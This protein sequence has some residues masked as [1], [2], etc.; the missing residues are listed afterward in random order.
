DKEEQLTYSEL[1]RCSNQ[2]AA[3]LIQEGVEKGDAVAV[4][5]S[6]DIATIINVVG[7]VKAGGIYIAI[8]KEYPKTRKEYILKNSN[9]KKVLSTQ[10]Y[11]EEIKDRY[12]SDEIDVEVS[13]EDIAYIIYTSGSTGEPKGVVISQKAVTNTIQD[14]NERFHVDSKD[15]IIGVSSMCFDLSVYDVFGALSTG[16]TLILVKDQRDPEELTRTVLESGV[17]IWNTVP[18]IMN[19]MIEHIAENQEE[20]KKYDFKKLRTI[21]LSGDWIPLKLPENIKNYFEKS[22]VISLGGATEASIWSIYYPINQMDETWKSIPYGMPLANQTI[23]ILSEEQKQ[24]PIGTKGEI[25]IGGKGVASGYKKDKEK[26]QKAF[27]DHDEL[28]RIYRT[29]DYG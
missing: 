4:I 5:A 1:D 17:S 18:A 20:Y 8:D 6:R 16:A 26:T 11:Q 9:A 27:I 3:Y 2:V 28:G 14:I 25:Y 7:I 22:Q 10:K 23:H 13:K 21:M 29:G 15:K 24:C 12:S 19:M